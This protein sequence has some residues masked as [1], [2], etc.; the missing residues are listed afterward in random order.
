MEASALINTPCQTPAFTLYVLYKS[1]GGI[2]GLFLRNDILYMFDSVF[3]QETKTSG[4]RLTTLDLKT[5]KRKEYPLLQY[6][7]TPFYWNKSFCYVDDSHAYY[8]GSGSPGIAIFPLD[9]SEPWSLGPDDGLPGDCPQGSASL[10]DKVYFGLDDRKGRSW[11]IVLD[12]K[13][14]KWEFLAS[15]TAKEGKTPFVNM[16]PGPNFYSFHVDVERNRLLMNVSVPRTAANGAEKEKIDGVWSIDGKSQEIVRVGQSQSWNINPRS[17]Q[18]CESG[19]SVSDMFVDAALLDEEKAR[20]VDAI[21]TI[22]RKCNIYEATLHR[23]YFWGSLWAEDWRSSDWA[24]LS[25]DGKS[26]PELLAVPESIETKARWTPSL[27]CRATSDGKS[28]VVADY[29]TVILL[30]LE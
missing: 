9:G 13:T 10:H 28:L 20:S 12:L 15:S 23:G 14:R 29:Y 6:K 19:L 7:G 18:F 2:N 26:E 21:K 24:R 5:M 30:R 8:Y 27:L 16:T 1:N 17:V 3:Q 11:L 25:I 4:I 22:S